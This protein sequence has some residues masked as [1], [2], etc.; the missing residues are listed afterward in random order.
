MALRFDPSTGR[1]IEEI[2]SGTKRSIVSG[3]SRTSGRMGKNV[4]SVLYYLLIVLGGLLILYL[5]AGVFDLPNLAELLLFLWGIGVFISFINVL[6][7]SGSWQW[8]LISL[9][10]TS[11]I[12]YCVYNIF[13]NMFIPESIDHGPGM[14][15]ETLE[16]RAVE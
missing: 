8:V 1:L 7:H 15:P 12:L 11:I 9:I 16:P 5:V 13:D 3:G 14:N 4:T 2:K 10:I 6:I